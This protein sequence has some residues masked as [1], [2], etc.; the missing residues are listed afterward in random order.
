MTVTISNLPNQSA[1]P[2]DNALIPIVEDSET[3]KILFQNLIKDLRCPVK[4][5][6]S[7]FIEQNQKN[8]DEKMFGFFNAVASGQALAS[9]TPVNTNVGVAHV[10]L[11]V[12]A[13]TDVIGD[14]TITGDTVTHADSK[15]ITAGDTEIISINGLTTDTSDTDADGNRRLAYTN[16]YK[17]GKIFRGDITISTTDV[18]LSDLDVVQIF[19]THSVAGITVNAFEIIARP[20]NGAAWMYSYLYGLTEDTA[21]KT[22]DLERIASVE[23][24]AALTE[25]NVGIL[26]IQEGIDF[27]APGTHAFFAETFFGPDAQSYWD[28]ISIRIEVKEN[29]S[30]TNI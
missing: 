5:I 30:L 20:T 21:L 28:D 17:T 7:T 2:D 13:G 16:L 12:N 1:A 26:G 23:I 19:T 10:V 15:D 27:T 24:P 14:I 8:L 22:M 4:K 29:I 25:A 9:G 18:D 11:I 3:R 6:Y